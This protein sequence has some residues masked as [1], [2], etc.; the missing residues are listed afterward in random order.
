MLRQFWSRLA[1]KSYLLLRLSYQ[2]TI[3]KSLKPPI[4]CVKNNKAFGF[5]FTTYFD[6]LKISSVVEAVQLTETIVPTIEIHDLL[7]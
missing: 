7:G 5:K 1:A 6:H 3:R 2:L 4:F